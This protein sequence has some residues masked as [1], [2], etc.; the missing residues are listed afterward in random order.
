MSVRTGNYLSP[1][2]TPVDTRCL[3]NN[4]KLHTVAIFIFLS[5]RKCALVFLILIS[6]A[7]FAAWNIYTQCH[8]YATAVFFN[9]YLVVIWKEFYFIFLL[10]INGL[11]KSNSLMVKGGKSFNCKRPTHKTIRQVRVFWHIFKMNRTRNFIV[12]G[13]KLHFLNV[14]GIVYCFILSYIICHVEI[15]LCHII[16]MKLQL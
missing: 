3:V 10:G 5:L 7:F 12:L 11:I 16:K 6:F 15:I 8:C 9:N 13:S 14:T 2:Q 1:K 4:W